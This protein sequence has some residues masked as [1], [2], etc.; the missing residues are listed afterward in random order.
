M[1]SSALTSNTT[2]SWPQSDADVDIIVFYLCI[3]HSQ[4]EKTR[5]I[6]NIVTAQYSAG[7]RAANMYTVMQLQARQ[8][9][10]D[11]TKKVGQ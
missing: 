11:Q 1:L 6:H 10:T 7:A 5:L 2:V 8:I 3:C 9:V 4:S